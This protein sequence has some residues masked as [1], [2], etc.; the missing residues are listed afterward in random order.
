MQLLSIPFME[1]TPVVKENKK[2][3]RKWINYRWIV[4]NVPF[5]LFLS[6]LAVIYI[7]NGHYADKTIRNINKA[8]KQL[9]ELEYEYKTLKS[10]VLFQSKQSELAKAVAPI[11]LKEMTTPAIIIQDSLTKE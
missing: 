5:F 7:Y 4:R 9:K 8:S 11:G 1:S 6:G 10:D 2:G 3:W